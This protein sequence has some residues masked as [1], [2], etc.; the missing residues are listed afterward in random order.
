MTDNMFTGVERYALRSQ[1]LDYAKSDAR[2]VGVAITG[3]ASMDREDEW[4]DIDLAFAVSSQGM[5][6]EVLADW[7]AWMYGR[8]Q[9]LHH[10]DVKAGAWIYRVFLLENTLQVDLAFVPEAEFRALG[11]AFRLISGTAQESR[12][13]AT[14]VVED[15]VGLGWLHALHA[16]SCIARQK[17]WQAEHMIGAIRGYTIVLA[18]LRLNLP[19]AHGRGADQLPSE[20]LEPLESSFV[21]R[22]NSI[23]LRRAFAVV[24][25]RFISEIRLSNTGLA[26]KLETPLLELAVDPEHSLG[27]PGNSHGR[28]TC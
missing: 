25:V 8:H 28:K 27:G 15:I 6:S 23:E 22:L 18:C 1:L 5:L 26:D 20:V 7:T 14:P 16:R 13:F 24:I 4:S 11:P 17:F 2:I 19:S 10:M 3:S 9:A 21:S 12:P